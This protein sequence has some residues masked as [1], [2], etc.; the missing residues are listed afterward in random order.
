MVPIIT[1][2][3]KKLMPEMLINTNTLKC[4]YHYS[5]IAKSMHNTVHHIKL[6]TD[7]YKKHTR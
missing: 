5:G 2:K 3:S 6:H 4:T 7:D 1:C